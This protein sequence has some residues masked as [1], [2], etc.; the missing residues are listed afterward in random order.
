M[1]PSPAEGIGS[2]RRPLEASGAD[3]PAREAAAGGGDR[4]HG[5]G[6]RRAAVGIC[7]VV[8]AAVAVA[9]VS[10]HGA[11]SAAPAHSP[12]PAARSAAKYGG[13]PSWL[14][15]AKVRVGRV[16]Q[17]SAALPA[18]SI[19][20]EEVSVSLMGGRVLATAVGPEVPEEGRYP[21]P[22]VTP[23]AFIVTFADASRTMPLSSSSFFF[24]DEQGRV[25]RPKVTALHGGAPPARIAPGHTVSV[26]L[27]DILPTGNGSLGWAPQGGHAIV[28]W[29]Y[30]VEID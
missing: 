18:L 23:C 25:H 8:M 24:V 7:C 9:L 1:Q 27:H 20:G 11:S 5:L 4:A 10:E 19:E 21:V 30:S 29:D 13:L 2:A 28:T 17:A 14:P 15:K 22:L 16:L 12:A 3:G 6:P 26:M